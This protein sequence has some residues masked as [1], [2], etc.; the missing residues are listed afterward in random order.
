M[1][2]K[3][4]LHHR[5]N[6]QSLKGWLNSKLKVLLKSYPTNEIFTK[7]KLKHFQVKSHILGITKPI[8]RYT[9]FVS[10]WI[11]SR[12]VYTRQGRLPLQLGGSKRRHKAE[13]CDY[14]CSSSKPKRWC[15][16]SA[17][18]ET[19][20]NGSPIWVMKFEKGSTAWKQQEKV[21]A[22]LNCQ[23]AV[24]FGCLWAQFP[25]SKVLS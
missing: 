6:Y 3:H 10:K 23:T 9:W 2:K 25:E 24:S 17:F 14:T 12:S 5:G 13:Q 19:D 7:R 22:L 15:G 20:K 4:F 16:T 21:N 1:K 8:D 11:R 18:G